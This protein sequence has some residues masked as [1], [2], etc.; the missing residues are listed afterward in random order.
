M[1]AMNISFSSPL[2]KFEFQIIIERI[3]LFICSQKKTFSYNATDEMD[4]LFVR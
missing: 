1:H 4:K 3:Q 2:G